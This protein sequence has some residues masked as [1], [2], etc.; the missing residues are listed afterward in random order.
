MLESIISL[1]LEGGG[2]I[3]NDLAKIL[4]TYVFPAILVVSALWA[5]WIGIAFVRATDEAARRAAK[6]RF[7]KALATIVI[8]AVLYL[9][10]LALGGNFTEIRK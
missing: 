7:L 3:G 10:M 5:V 2:G 9:I 4:N 6:D 1:L 8:I